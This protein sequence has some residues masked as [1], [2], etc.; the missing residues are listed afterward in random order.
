MSS[1]FDSLGTKRQQTATIF[2]IHT[3]KSEELAISPDCRA[4]IAL[5]PEVFRTAPVDFQ[6]YYFIARTA[7]EQ[8]LS[9]RAVSPSFCSCC[10]RKH[11]VPSDIYTTREPRVHTPLRDYFNFLQGCCWIDRFFASWDDL[12]VR[13]GYD[14]VWTKVFILGK[15]WMVFWLSR[16]VITKYYILRYGNWMICCRHWR[17]ADCL[18]IIFIL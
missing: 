6:S 18:D 10:R 9:P 8:P 14:G 1:S 15:F 11:T 5:G 4:I 12:I 13:V 16:C 2:S 17:K 7:S 3:S